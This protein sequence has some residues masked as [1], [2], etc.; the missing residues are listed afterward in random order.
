[1]FNSVTTKY[2][3][4]RFATSCHFQFSHPVKVKV[5]FVGMIHLLQGQSAPEIIA[6]G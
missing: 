3:P 4:Q 5:N 1:M 6:V 2:T